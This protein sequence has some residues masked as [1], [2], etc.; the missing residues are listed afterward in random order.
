MIGEKNIRIL[1]LDIAHYKIDPSLD[2]IICDF[3]KP[4][5]DYCV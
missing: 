4:N 5:I 3:N 2:K 1:Y